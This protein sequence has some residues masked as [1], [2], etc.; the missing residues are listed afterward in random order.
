M[1]SDT[2]LEITEL[3]VGKWTRDYKNFLEELAQKDEIEDIREYHQENRVHF[4]LVVPKLRQISEKPDGILKK[5]R[6][7]TTI[8]ASNYVLFNS[9]SK[10]YKYGTEVDIMKEFFGQRERFVGHPEHGDRPGCRTNGSGCPTNGVCR[11]AG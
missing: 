2:E 3:P 9:E 7:S 5:F 4:H 6:L 10:I 11:G 8:S 1:L